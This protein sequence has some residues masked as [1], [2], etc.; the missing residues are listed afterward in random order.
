MLRITA[1]QGTWNV[2]QMNGIC[3]WCERGQFLDGLEM[4]LN[5]FK[6]NFLDVLNMFLVDFELYSFNIL[7]FIILG[8]FAWK[9]RTQIHK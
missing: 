5:F 3:L 9:G 7:L 2:S 1:Q 4:V 8:S 6:N